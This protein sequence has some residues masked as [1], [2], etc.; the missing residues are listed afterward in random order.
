MTSDPR[1]SNAGPGSIAHH[2]LITTIDQEADE[3]ESFPIADLLGQSFVLL[4]GH[5]AIDWVRAGRNVKAEESSWL[6]NLDVYQ[7]RA[8]INKSFYGRYDISAF[9]CVLIRPDGFVAWSE[10]KRAVYG[11]GAMGMPDSEAV[12]KCVLREILCLQPSIGQRP[13]LPENSTPSNSYTPATESFSTKL[14]QEIKS[15]EG[16]KAELLT[17]VAEVDEKLKCLRRMIEVQNEMVMLAM[18]LGCSPLVSPGT[19]N[20]VLLD[21][22]L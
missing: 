16:E 20:K 9:G 3:P 2:V 22:N 11:L 14:F 8:R 5:E 12:L 7:L 17:K 18:K 13:V 10:T 4:C 21:D 15:L 1:T 6:P 19:G